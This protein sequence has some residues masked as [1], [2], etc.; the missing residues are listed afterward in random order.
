LDHRWSGVPASPLAVQ[1]AT[2]D[3]RAAREAG[4]DARPEVCCR[5]MLRRSHGRLGEIGRRRNL[6]LAA[7]LAV[8]GM[9]SIAAAAP[10]VANRL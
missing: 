3:S 8:V 1:A 9:P 4:I 6:T 10:G 2:H 7:S 5:P